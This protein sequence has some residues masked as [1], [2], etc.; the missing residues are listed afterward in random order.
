MQTTFILSHMYRSNLIVSIL[1]VVFFILPFGAKAEKLNLKNPYIVIDANSGDILVGQNINDR[2]Y[3]A[4]LT[5][6]MTAYVT[7]RAIKSGKIEDGSPVIISNA[8]RK[9]PP[10]RMGYKQ[11]VSLRIDTALK[12]IIIKSAN[13]VS[14][15]LAE[16]VAGSLKNFVAR[17]NSEANR[18][19]MANTKF[20]NSNGLHSANQVSSARDMALLSAQILKEFPQ[21]AYMFEAAAIKTP[22]KTHYSYNLLLERFKGANGMKTGFV[23]ASGYNLVGSAT[24]NGRSLIAVVMGTSSQTERAVSA[25]QLLEAGF[26]NTSARIGNIYSAASQGS[27][28]KN[29]RPILCTEQARSSRYDP[30]AGQAKINSPHLHPR[31]ISSKILNITTGG[32][33]GP[34]STASFAN[35]GTI[36]VPTK[37]PKNVLN[38]GPIVL[39]TIGSAATGEIPLPTKRP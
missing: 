26:Q 29:M 39:E 38:V 23:C 28:P 4:S 32:I 16:A 19:G 10:S 27:K 20:A 18:L 30:G 1:T 2:W 11:G 36:P 31:R 7:F 9:Q 21:Y 17:M 15:A 12:I 35:V 37:R 25:A 6:L 22:V 24:R 14:H 3:P 8:A 34:A 5:K 33:D 13:D